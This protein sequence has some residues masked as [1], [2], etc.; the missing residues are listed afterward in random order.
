[1]IGRLSEL[2]VTIR[3]LVRTPSRPDGDERMNGGGDEGQSGLLPIVRQQRS[4]EM[5]YFL[6]AS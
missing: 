3:E 5:S 4:R 1:M 2:N 6:S